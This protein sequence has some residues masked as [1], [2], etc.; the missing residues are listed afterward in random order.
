MSKLNYG[1]GA[2]I[3]HRRAYVSWAQMRSRC[4]N[5]KNPGYKNYGGRGITICSRWDEF[6][7]FLEDMGDRP[8]GLFLDRKDNDGLYCQENCH[9]ASRTAQNRNRRS[10]KL[11]LEKVEKIRGAYVR[12]VTRQED[13]GKQFGISRILTAKVV[14]GVLWKA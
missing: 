11:S 13:I 6:L 14:Q 7:N 1:S 2:C 12:G 5:P 3:R 10:V 8:P 4:R 9:W